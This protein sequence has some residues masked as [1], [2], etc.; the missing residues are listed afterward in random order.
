MNKGKVTSKKKEL[1]ICIIILAIGGVAGYFISNLFNYSS[2]E[3]YKLEDKVEFLT[4]DIE[5]D[6]VVLVYLTWS[7]K[8]GEK[9]TNNMLNMY[10]DHLSDKMAKELPEGSE[11]CLF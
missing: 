4:E 1:K 2:T 8:N 5:D 10:G 3:Y 9:S 6:V 7:V 11:I